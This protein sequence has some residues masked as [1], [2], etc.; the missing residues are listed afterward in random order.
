M[1]TDRRHTNSSLIVTAITSLSGPLTLSPEMQIPELLTG[2]LEESQESWE[3]RFYTP[4]P[5]GSDL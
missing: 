5:P 3:E 1:E 2:L 4:P